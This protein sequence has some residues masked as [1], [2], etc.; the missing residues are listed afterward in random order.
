[1][2]K[3][4]YRLQHRVLGTG[5]FGAVYLAWDT[6]AK[7][8]VACKRQR[9]PTSSD[10]NERNDRNMR[11][12]L[13][14][15]SKVDHPCINALYEWTEHD[16]YLYMFLEAAPGTDLF[17]WISD[18]T[19]YPRESQVLYIT[20]QLLQ[21]LKYLHDQ[22]IAHRDLK[23]ENVLLKS[24]AAEYPQVQLADF[25]LAWEHDTLGQDGTT[26]PAIAHTNQGTV[27]YQPPDLH[28]AVVTQEGYD[29]F[30]TDSWALGCILILLFT[31]CQAFDSPPD[32]FPGNDFPLYVQEYLLNEGHVS[33]EYLYQ[34][35]LLLHE[36]SA[37]D[38]DKR[39]EGLRALTRKLFSGF[40]WENIY[41]AER[42]SQEGRDLASALVEVD[43]TVRATVGQ[44][45]ESEWIL[46]AEVGLKKMVSQG[47]QSRQKH[48]LTDLW[49]PLWLS[50]MFESSTS[51][52]LATTII[53]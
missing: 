52:R 7:R 41:R 18:G 8:Q 28:M 49:H 1:M 20:Y 22:G 26:P 42:I 23:P 27:Y 17:N 15:H 51:D 21:A 35:G 24:S 48:H 46:Q 13:R 12:E 34:E 2:I 43:P 4:R 25:G 47:D 45:L 38:S 11:R 40:Q 44:A 19:E 10:G 39:K 36:V 37:N 53:E 29:P 5:T 14:I 6:T 30:L 3:D 31:R 50:M 16:G 32:A 9:I 33:E